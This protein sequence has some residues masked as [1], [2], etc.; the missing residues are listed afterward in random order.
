MMLK[1]V[2]RILEREDQEKIVKN[3]FGVPH[4]YRGYYDSL[5]FEPKENVSVADM[6]KDAKQSMGKTFTGWKG[7]E[8]VMDERTDVY[9]AEIGHC[10]TDE[11]DELTE[12]RLY[13]MLEGIDG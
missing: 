2:I 6:L 12:K 5:A 7:G 3:G 13:L 10:G 11:D 1:D 9:I 4:S 8:F